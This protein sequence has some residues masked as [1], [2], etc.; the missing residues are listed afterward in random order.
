MSQPLS[1][2]H[3]RVG[4]LQQ[5]AD[6][7]QVWEA[8][9]ARHGVEKPVP[10]WKTSLDGTW[11]ALDRRGHTASGVQRRT[12]NDDLARSVYGHVPY[13]ESRLL[14]LAHSLVA[15]D[16]LSE[17]ELARRLETVRSAWRRHEDPGEWAIYV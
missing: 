6:H 15:H 2:T 9:A 12:E 5:I 17:D 11:D 10:P 4:V 8:V 3:P 14:A 7:G 1:E 13:P 16:V